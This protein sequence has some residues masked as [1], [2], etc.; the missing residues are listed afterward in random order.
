MNKH[1]AL[2]KP[3]F[4]RVDEILSIELTSTGSAIWTRP[5]GGNFTSL[6]MTMGSAKR[7]IELSAVVGVKLTGAGAPFPYGD[8]KLD[9]NIR[10]APS[11]P[12]LDEIDSATKVLA[13]C[14]KVAALEASLE[15]SYPSQA[16]T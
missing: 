1:A 2:L 15:H 10:I 12:S 8:D 5:N 9:H 7:A 13:L 16:R 6:D 3:K 11:F 4:D 14:V